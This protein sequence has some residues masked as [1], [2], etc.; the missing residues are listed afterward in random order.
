MNVSTLQMS[1]KAKCLNVN[2]YFLFHIQHNIKETLPY[3]YHLYLIFYSHLKLVLWTGSLHLFAHTLL[4]ILSFVESHPMLRHIHPPASSTLGLEAVL[5][6]SLLFPS[7][8]TVMTWCN[9]ETYEWSPR[10]MCRTVDI[11]R[12]N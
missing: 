10:G 4:S 12:H 9:I 2:C 6:N 5:H 7:R 3:L 1:I 8:D 11:V